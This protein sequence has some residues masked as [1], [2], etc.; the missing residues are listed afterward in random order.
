MPIVGIGADV[1]GDVPDIMGAAGKDD[2][3]AAKDVA[4]MARHQSDGESSGCHRP[5]R[6]G[7]GA[8]VYAA[9]RPPHGSLGP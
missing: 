6:L 3:R 7:G 2:K 5:V 1:M 9:L 4:D 8:V